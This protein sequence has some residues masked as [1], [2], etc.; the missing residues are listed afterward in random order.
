MELNEVK[1]NRT[2]P[3]GARRDSPL[4][5]L[6]DEDLA[7]VVDLVLESGSLKGLAKVYS[8]SYPTIR[9]RL[10]KLIERLKAVIDGKPPDP[11]REYLADLIRRGVMNI[12]TARRIAELA[13]TIGQQTEGDSP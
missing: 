2:E 4:F 7:L 10:D 3:P 9:A 6:S 13:E 1:T 5:G 8:V 12:D 11:L